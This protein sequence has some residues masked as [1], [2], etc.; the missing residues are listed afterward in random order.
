VT[1]PPDP[2]L[3]CF[4]GSDDSSRAIDTAA[5]LFGGG[6][7][8]VLTVWEPSVSALASFNPLGQVVGMASGLFEDMDEMAAELAGERAR[9]G[10]SL[11]AKAGFETEPRAVKGKTWQ[12]IVATADEENARGV[13]LG[14]RGLGSVRSTLMGGTSAAVVHHCRRPILVVP[15]AAERTVL[16]DDPR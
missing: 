9:E 5:R 4:D 11:A 3:I 8:I 14:A 12:A 1:V 13:V 15:P 2:L 10:A 6:R 7:A 16:R